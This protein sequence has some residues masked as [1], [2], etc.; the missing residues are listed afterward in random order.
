MNET[1]VTVAC[2]RCATVLDESQSLPPEE[3]Q[4]CAN[5]GSV[6]RHAHVHVF[7][8]GVEVH[9]SVSI[10]AKRPGLKRPF[11]EGKYG[12]SFHHDTG[13]WNERRMTI[14]REQNRYQERIVDPQTGRVLRDV[15]EPLDQ[16]RGR[17]LARKT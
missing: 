8:T 2:G 12:D 4:P 10:K 13:K 3:R 16:H 11:R 1:S 15:D 14:D 6:A 9:E 17:G 5:C 7:D